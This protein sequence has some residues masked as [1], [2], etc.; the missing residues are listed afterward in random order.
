MSDK[1]IRVS[2]IADYVYC[3]RA[4]WYRRVTGL[5]SQNATE[6]TRGTAF[7]DDHG[8]EVGRSLYLRRLAY[9]LLALAAAVV[10]FGL[11]RGW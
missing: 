6:L 1:W 10:V 8:A 3:H 7:H 11:L 2:E 4:W 5:E 9:V